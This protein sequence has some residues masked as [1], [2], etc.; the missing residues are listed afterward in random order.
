MSRPVSQEVSDLWRGTALNSVNISDNFSHREFTATLQ[1]LKPCIAPGLD[2]ICP[3][4]IL[5]AGAALK[6]FG[7]VTSFLPVCGDSKSSRSGEERL[8]RDPKANKTHGGPKELSIDFSALCLERL[9][10]ARVE[11]VID[12][13]L[14]KEQAG[15]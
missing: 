14:P 4:L 12:P 3:E 1:H 10:Y 8:N 13:L 5:N 2:F 7:Y 6:S 9:I 11:P 15:F